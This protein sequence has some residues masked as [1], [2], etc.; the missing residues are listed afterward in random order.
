MHI[1]NGSQAQTTHHAGG[2]SRLVPHEG[3]F[4]SYGKGFIDDKEALI[5]E[6]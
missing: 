6:L 1:Q 3:H 5:L 2:R 4:V